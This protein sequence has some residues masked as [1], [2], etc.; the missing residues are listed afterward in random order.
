MTIFRCNKTTK[1][2]TNKQTNKINSLFSLYLI[3]FL[4]VLAILNLDFIIIPDDILRIFEKP[5]E[6]F[7]DLLM[8]S[9]F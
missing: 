8:M 2:K 6:S 9:I 5:V 1:E 4:F 7:Y 3:P